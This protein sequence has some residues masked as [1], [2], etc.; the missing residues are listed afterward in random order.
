VQPR[1]V[2]EPLP[3]P[4][5]TP[6][7]EPEDAFDEEGERTLQNIMDMGYERQQV[8]KCSLLFIL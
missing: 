8:G 7:S 2:V 3:S 5:E 4:V 1:V 6:A